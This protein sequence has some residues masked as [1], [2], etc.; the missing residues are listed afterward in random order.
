LWGKALREV[1]CTAA[2]RW[3]EEAL[4][5]AANLTDDEFVY[6]HDAVLTKM[7]DLWPDTALR[8]LKEHPDTTRMEDHAMTA[9]ESLLK[10]GSPLSTETAAL[11][12]DILQPYVRIVTALARNDPAA[13]AAA[14][15]PGMARPDIDRSKPVV[16]EIA[17]HYALVDPAAALSWATSV[18]EPMDCCRAT[19]AAARIAVQS[20]PWAVSVWLNATP[21]SREVDRVIT[22]LL[23]ELDD[24]PQAAYAW[25]GRFSSPGRRDAEQ[26]RILR[27]NPLYSPVTEGLLPSEDHP[28][29]PDQ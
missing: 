26:S 16:R 13:A 18:P 24:D 17:M 14:W 11:F 6:A 10:S 19:T 29:S 28:T 25:A 4:K 3:P 21:P 15:A 22:I 9:L 5:E 20:N 8:Y 1:L 23:D 2:I 27:E 12:P 7:A